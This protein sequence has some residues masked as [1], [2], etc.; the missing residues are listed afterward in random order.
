MVHKD[1]DG[2]LFFD[3]RMGGGLRRQGDFVIPE[4]IEKAMA[5]FS[6]V[7]DVCVYGVPAESGAPGESDIVAALNAV[8]GQEIIPKNI[9]EALLNSDLEKSFIPTYLQVVDEI[10]KTA[11]EKNLGRLLKDDFSKDASNVFKY[12]DCMK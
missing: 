10:P 3:F 11:S 1:E 9:F 2:W 6:E 7:S 12:P 5:E 8:P 4:S